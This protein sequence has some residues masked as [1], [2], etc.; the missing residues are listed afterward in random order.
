MSTYHHDDDEELVSPYERSRQAV[1]EYYTSGG[2]AERTDIFAMLFT[3]REQPGLDINSLSRSRVNYRSSRGTGLQ[4]QIR[5]RIINTIDKALRHKLVEKDGKGFL[6]TCKG[7]QFVLGGV[8]SR[9]TTHK[10]GQFD[11]STACNLCAE[12]ELPPQS[13]TPVE[14]TDRRPPIGQDLARCM[15]FWPR[16]FSNS[17]FASA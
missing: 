4:P 1:F 17:G 3:L 14:E 15:G 16:G 13:L 12:G 8:H 2:G 5:K 7:R 6:L 10:T 11:I 9:A